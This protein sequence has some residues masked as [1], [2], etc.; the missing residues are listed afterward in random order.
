MTK[1][2]ILKNVTTFES[3]TQLF[4]K[5]LDMYNNKITRKL[6]LMKWTLIPPQSLHYFVFPGLSFSLKQHYLFLIEVQPRHKYNA[7]ELGPDGVRIRD[8][9]TMDSTF[10]ALEI[11]TLTTEPSRTALCN[12]LNGMNLI[13]NRIAYTIKYH[14]C[15]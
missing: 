7:H 14:H 1:S 2:R 11:L 15:M 13:M 9:Q 6:V 8:F 5:G 4:L 3:D 12:H 10:H